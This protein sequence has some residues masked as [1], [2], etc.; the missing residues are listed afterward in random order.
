MAKKLHVSQRA[1]RRWCGRY[2]DTGTVD[3]NPRS[4][5]R[6]AMPPD[7]QLAALDILLDGKTG[8]AKQVAMELKRSGK[9]A[10]VLSSATIIRAARRCAPERGIKR[11]RALRGR[12]RKLLSAATRQRR[13]DFCLRNEQRSWKTT[14]FTDRKKFPF[15]YPGSKVHLVT[16]VADGGERRAHQVNHAN[17]V[18]VYAGVTPYGMT[19]LHVV[20]GTTGHKTCH[21]TKQG[22]E[23]KNITASEYKLVL[24][25]T[26]LPEGAGLFRTQGISSWTLQQ[27]NDPTHKAAADIIKEYNYKNASSISLLKEW[28]PTSPDLSLIENVWAILQQ[29]MDSKGCKTF[30]EFKEALKREAAELSKHVCKRLFDGMHERVRCCIARGGEYTKH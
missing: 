19:K 6:T 28:P 20:A 4:G 27:D 22:K 5:R 8:G 2:K 25:Q 11:L 21:M 15:S 12:P 9:T 24:E 23:A 26:L 16:W 18:N 13:L 1:V 3:D 14:M 17:V 10:K 29:R 30:S 7:V